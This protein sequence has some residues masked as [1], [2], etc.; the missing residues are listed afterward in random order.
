MTRWKRPVLLFV[1]IATGLLLVTLVSR[2]AWD[3]PVPDLTDSDPA[4]VRSGSDLVAAPAGA[5]RNALEVTEPA[6]DKAPRAVTDAPSPAVAGRDVKE[7]IAGAEIFIHVVDEQHRPLDG[8]RVMISREGRTTERE[9]RKGTARFLRAQGSYAVSVACEGYASAQDTVEVGAALVSVERTITLR[10]LTDQDWIVGLVLDRL[11]KPVRRASVS[12]RP[13]TDEHGVASADQVEEWSD[14]EGRFSLAICRD[15]PILISASR[16][17]G[18]FSSERRIEPGQTEVTLQ[19]EPPGDVWIDLI[20]TP[21]GY[22]TRLGMVHWLLVRQDDGRE[23]SGR[24][25]SER[26]RVKGLRMGVYELYVNLIQ[27][28]LYARRTITVSGEGTEFEVPLERRE[29]VE[30]TLVRPD[31]SIASGLNVC[32]LETDLPAPVIAAWGFSTT[33]RDGRFR[34]MLGP[35]GRARAV[36]RTMKKKE[37]GL[38]DLVA[39]QGTYVLR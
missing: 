16:S 6:A 5:G 26:F 23:A 36:V 31:G 19:F 30:G 15:T 32:L 38:L 28:G 20:G 17:K 29:F 4:P 22:G 37:L 27:D 35:S 34:L 39:G 18:E 2:P 7:S 25:Q 14:E 8:A 24:S 3:A 10:A 21:A 13:D 9:T 11:G 12:A 1:G 33:S